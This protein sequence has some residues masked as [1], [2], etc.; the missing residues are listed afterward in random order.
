MPR[1]PITNIET[2][3]GS[4]AQAKNISSSSWFRYDYICVSSYGRYECEKGR[5]ARSALW[6]G[7]GR[8]GW[9]GRMAMV[10]PLP[11][12]HVAISAAHGHVKHPFSPC[13]APLC[14]YDPPQPSGAVEGAGLNVAPLAKRRY[15]LRVTQ[16]LGV[17]CGLSPFC[18]CW[19]LWLGLQP[20]RTIH[21]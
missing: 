16:S 3:L 13:H 6:K 2:L 11:L 12:C 20:S 9:G 19:S 1:G 10:E 4:W 8:L 14:V 17:P 7:A 5:W 21:R 18:R 15:R